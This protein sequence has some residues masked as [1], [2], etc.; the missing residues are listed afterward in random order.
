MNVFDKIKKSWW[1]ILSIIMFLNG[2]GFIYIGVK[3]N[4]RNWILEGIMYELPWFL[5]FLFFSI[6]G[7]PMD[8]PLNPSYLIVAFAFIML[9]VS[10]IRS[11]WVA[12]KLSDVYENEEKYTISS[13]SL[14]SSKDLKNTK[15]TNSGI[16]CC[17]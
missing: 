6:F 15:D 3:Y 11:I 17:L 13:T 10:V 16:A 12:V 7:N 8:T 14:N 2:F 1:V 5:Y 9:F 4:N